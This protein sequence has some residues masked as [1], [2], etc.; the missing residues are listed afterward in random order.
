MNFDD[1]LRPNE[2]LLGERNYETATRLML[3]RAERE[4]RIFDPD[5]SRGGYQSLETYQ[6]LASFLSRDRLNRLTIIL[7]DGQFFFQRCPRLVELMRRFTHTVTIYLTDARGHV[8]Q[9]AFVLADRSDYLHRFHVD[10]ARFKYVNGDELAAN[11][12]YQRF[13]QLLAVT[14]SRLSVSTTGL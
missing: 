1:A 8:A 9:D 3:E 5:L 4:L 12:L 11:P 7:H 6:S 13:E 2:V 14:E 10:H